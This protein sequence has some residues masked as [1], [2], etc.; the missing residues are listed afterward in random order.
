MDAC[1]PLKAF[2]NG[3]PML[4]YFADRDRFCH[5]EQVVLAA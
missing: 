1:L 4:Y 3:V 5:L 2:A